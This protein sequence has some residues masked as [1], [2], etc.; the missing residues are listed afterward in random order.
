MPCYDPRVEQMQDDEKRRRLQAEAIL[1]GIL[2]A[3]PNAFDAVDWNETGV[4]RWDADFWWRKHKIEDA[5]RI[6]KE[7]EERKLLAILKQKYGE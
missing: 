4:S 2:R 1:C 6:K 3:L 5:K 7:Q